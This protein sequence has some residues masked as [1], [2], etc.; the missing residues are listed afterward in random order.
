MLD[1]FFLNQGKNKGFS[2]KEHGIFYLNRL[3]LSKEEKV[4]IIEGIE[5]RIK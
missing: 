2:Y 1:K 3:D 5:K 4:A